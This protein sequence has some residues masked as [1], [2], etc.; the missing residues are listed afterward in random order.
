MES[1]PRLLGYPKAARTCV[2]THVRSGSR[3]VALELVILSYLVSCN[4]IGLA[5]FLRSPRLDIFLRL[6]ESLV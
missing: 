3:S 5:F 6:G 4:F 1:G 2:I